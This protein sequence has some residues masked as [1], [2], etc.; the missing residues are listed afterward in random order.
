MR[1]TSYPSGE[2]CAFRIDE[3]SGLPV[4]RLPALADGAALTPLTAAMLSDGPWCP[5]EANAKRWDADLLRIRKVGVTIRVEAAASALRG[6]AERAVCQWRDF[7]RRQSMGAGSGDPVPGVAAKHE[8]GA[9]MNGLAREDGVAML[10]AMM[11]IL[12]M[13]AFG[14][15]LILSSS[16]ETIIAGHFRDCPRRRLCR[17]RDAGA[18]TGRSPGNGRLESGHRGPA[19]VPLGRRS[20]DRRSNACRRIE[21]RPV[22]GRQHGELSEELRHA[23]RRISSR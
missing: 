1:P 12:I 13:T 4:A 21:H 20:T 7:S 23:R 18:R 3:A 6:P 22:A 17:G 8:P 5:D 10:V 15:A 19:S 11:A 2:N 9:G 16:S 14:T